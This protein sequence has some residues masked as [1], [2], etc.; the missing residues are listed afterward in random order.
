MTNI[1]KDYF[2]LSKEE[3][4]KKRDELINNELTYCFLIMH[5]FIHQQRK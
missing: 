1:K 3:F 2:K 4:D 5:T